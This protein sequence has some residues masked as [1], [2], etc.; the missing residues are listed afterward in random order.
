MKLNLLRLNF[1]TS[2][3]E[4]MHN[5]ELDYFIGYYKIPRLSFPECCWDCPKCRGKTFT[6]K[7]GA[8]SCLECPKGTWPND[9][10][11]ACAPIQPVYLSWTEGWALVMISISSAG[12]MAVAFTFAV[13]FMFHNTAV[14]KA[15][16]RH[17]CYILLLGIAMFFATPVV[18][19]AKPTIS[20]CRLLPFFFGM[21]FV[22]VVGK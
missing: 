19:I 21:C 17:L 20:S 9:F 18:Y 10:H 8:T 15:A 14:V 5:V 16:S 12:V 7:K 2:H 13:F 11:S 3:R 22:M 6:N 4:G 1:F